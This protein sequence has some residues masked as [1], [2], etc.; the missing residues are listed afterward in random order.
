VPPYDQSVGVLLLSVYIF[1]T[2]IFQI[3]VL[4]RMTVRT[5]SKD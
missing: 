4:L 3:L 1:E 5:F 2:F